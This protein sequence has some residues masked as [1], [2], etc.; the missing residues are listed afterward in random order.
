MRLLPTPARAHVAAQPSGSGPGALG[1]FGAASSSSELLG[2]GAPT[3]RFR[4]GAGA[5][6]GAG[7]GAGAGAGAGASRRP[8]M[9][10]SRQTN[11]SSLS[12]PEYQ[13]A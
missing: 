7:G 13:S 1:F 4:F 10:R 5:G 3:R 6:A 8:A 9:D 2:S 11:R 12:A